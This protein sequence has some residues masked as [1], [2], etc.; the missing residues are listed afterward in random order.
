MPL[1]PASPY[2]EIRMNLYFLAKTLHLISLVAW[3]AG[4]F[5]LPRLFAYHAGVAPKSPEST[6]FKVMERRLLKAI[7]TPAMISTWIFGIWLVA[8]TGYGSEQNPAPWLAAKLLFVLGLSGLH[9]FFAGCVRKFSL[10]QNTRSVRFYKVINECV[11]LMFM[12]IV[13][14]VVFKPQF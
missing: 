2:R 13:A 3:M 8:I 4:M 7:M 12:A 11:T 6:I 1:P 10:N 9:G 14:L 5:Y